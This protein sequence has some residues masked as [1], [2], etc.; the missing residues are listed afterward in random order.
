MEYGKVFLGYLFLMFLWPSVVFYKHLQSKSKVY[1]FGFCV[2]T[3]PVLVNTVVLCLGLLHILN[4]WGVILLFY[5]TF[6]AVV[7]KRFHINH[8]KIEQLYRV[9]TGVYGVKTFLLGNLKEWIRKQVSRLWNIVKV[10]FWEYMLLFI[11]LVYGMVYFS[12]GVF[13]DPTYGASDMYTHHSWIYGLV[14]GQAFSGKVY[15]EGMH[16]FIY[17]IYALFGIRVY[18]VLLFL[19]GIHIITFLLSAYCLM[20]EIFRWRF[21]PF[22]VLTMFLTIDLVSVNEIVSM[23]RLQWTIP[24]EFGLYTQFICALFLLRYLKAVPHTVRK[25]KLLRN[26]WDENLYVFMMALTASIAIH[27]YTTIIAFFLCLAF[28]VTGLGRILTKGH[29]LPLV[30]AV[31]TGFFIAVVPMALALASG[32]PFHGSI[33]WAVSVMEGGKG[34]KETELDEEELLEL[35]RTEREE[36]LLEN[37]EIQEPMEEAWEKEDREALE[38]DIVTS[39]L[40]DNRTSWEKLQDMGQKA[41]A[42]FRQRFPRVFWGGYNALY[43]TERAQWIVRLTGLAFAL[44]L[45]YW[46][47][48]LVLSIP[49]KGKINVS[50]F[51]GYP[52]VIL[53]SVLYM[54]VY[55]SGYLGLPQLIEGLRICSSEQML[56]LMV[57]AIPVDMLFSLLALLCRDWMM[58]GLSLVCVG[59]VCVLVNML[60]CYHGYLC[61]ALTRYSATAAVTNSIIETL[62]RHQY[63]I[64]SPTEELYQIIEYGRHEELWTFVQE[65]QESNY[66]LP[67]EYVFLYIEK[68]PIQCP[69]YHFFQ[70][71]SWLALE[72]YTKHF[73]FAISQCPEVISTEISEEMAQEE[74]RSFAQMYQA[75]QDQRNR[76]ILESKVYD[77]CQ[78]FSQL[79]PFELNVYYEDEDFI[80]YYF[81]QEPNAP[82]DLGIG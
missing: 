11:L 75:Y 43:G 39:D 62:P 53:A 22:L 65:V 60:G 30:A 20:R 48:A 25:G 73:N 29:F 15:P 44:W 66:I 5:G 33:G 14:E 54:V 49:F 72:K 58:Q 45:L 10:H 78:R 35:E 51:N 59:G 2:A 50:C 63:T 24:Q 64:V 40:P 4:R 42:I 32:I 3:Q 82:Y 74:T 23:A 18:S 34:S 13:Q 70:G 9:A 37:N 81:R 55:T 71:P 28:A 77:W 6:I 21:T 67:T 80:C 61:H 7:C 31:I 76:T 52:A 46:F 56:I 17:A 47:F 16:C 36:R 1:R 69:Q 68:K 19:A 41:M 57:L 12:Y 27:F 38:E 8:K 79:Y 26:C